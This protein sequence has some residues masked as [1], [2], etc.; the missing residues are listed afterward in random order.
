VKSVT[1]PNADGSY[2]VGD[3]IFIDI[4]FNVPVVVTGVPRLQ[5]ETGVTGRY[6]TYTSGS[7]TSTL[8][9]A[10]TVQSGDHSS[11]LDYFS[12]AALGLNGGT[13]EDFFENLVALFLPTP[14]QAGSLGAN[15][16][17]QIV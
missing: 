11:D 2:T 16:D 4:T 3:I 13:I 10:Y 9:F 17:I 5:L 8:R 15:D 6:A 12:S 7:G 1:S 14:G